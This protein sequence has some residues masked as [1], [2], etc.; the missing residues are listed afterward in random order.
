[1]TSQDLASS[2]FCAAFLATLSSPPAFAQAV[3]APAV[4]PPA[5][6]SAPSELDN[7]LNTRLPNSSGR[8][9]LGLNVGNLLTGVTAKLWAAPNVAF[10]AAVGE[11]AEG[12]D[13]RTHLDL[14]FC[15]GTW[16]SPDGKYVLPFYVGIG[17][18]LG[19][20]FASGLSLSYTEG[21]FR[22]PLGMSVMVRGNP[23][24]LF[25]EVAPEFTV[26]SN[27]TLA[28]KYGVYTDGAIGARYY[29]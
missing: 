26:R 8:L 13:L 15:P 29:F 10:Q 25:F 16:T 3:A 22:V 2:A 17:G 20:N 4:I 27:A 19:H 21:G 9:G 12:N 6:A 28:G 11:G 18:A 7:Y 14:L 5:Q 23:I 1:M 24:E